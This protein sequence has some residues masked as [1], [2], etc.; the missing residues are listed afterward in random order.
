VPAVAKYL[1]FLF[2]STSLTDVGC[3]MRLVSRAVLDRIVREFRVGG[4]HFGPEMMLLCIWSGASLIEIPVNYKKRIGQ[5]MVT[6]S[7]WSAFVLGLRMILQITS[8]R[9]RTWAGLAPKMLRGGLEAVGHQKSKRKKSL[10][11]LPD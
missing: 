7:R 4:S 5:S 6:G 3:T 9:F 11:H 10:R 2:N 1:E 8:F